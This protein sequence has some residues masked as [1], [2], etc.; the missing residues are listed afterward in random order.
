MTQFM[1]KPSMKNI[2]HS[3]TWTW[4]MRRYMT[5]ACAGLALMVTTGAAQEPM[6]ENYQSV[7]SSVDYYATNFGVF[8]QST[9]SGLPGLTYPRGSSKGY[10][11]GSGLWFGAQKLVGT[12][13]KKLVFVTYNP[14]SAKSWARPGEYLSQQDDAPSLLLRSTD[15]SSFN[16]KYSGAAERPNWP[17][18]LGLGMGATAMRPGIYVPL[19]S[20]RRR[21][22]GFFW[23]AMVEGVAEQF[24]SRF[25]DSSLAL[26]EVVDPAERAG[27]P[28]GLQFQQN[29]FSFEEG[30]YGSVVMI[31]YQIINQSPDTLFHC[32]AGQ[33][34]DPDLGNL[35]NDRLRFHAERPELRSAYVWTDDEGSGHGALAVSIIEA[36]VTDNSGFIDNASRND[37]K[38]MGRAGAFPR[39]NSDASLV[40]FAARYDFMTNG[41]F[42]E[43]E[44]PGDQRALMASTSF[45]MRPGDTAYFTVSYTV[46]DVPP[47]GKPRRGGPRSLVDRNTE[48][49]DSF[50]SLLVDLLDDYY[51]RGV[52]SQV[53]TLGLPEP[54][55]EMSVT[56]MPNPAHDRA[57]ISMTLVEPANASLR[58]TNALG[59]T[60]LVRDLGLRSAG[61]YHEHIDATALPS[62]LYFA[63]VEVGGRTFM[64]RLVL[65]R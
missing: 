23:P 38:T 59:Q 44:G 46:L 30:E 29:I 9:I 31:Q 4:V 54:E 42:A 13:W 2:Q 22:D 65:M 1:R 63:M 7:K 52:F 39:L 15:Y 11:F 28:M 51:E 18:W 35:A 8:G 50:P 27:A 26:Y 53:S 47:A 20:A 58:I 43:D 37:Y 19:N 62:G 16:G 64:T 34:S 14:S 56:A 21:G 55:T 32:V 45:S 49:Q 10:L 25:H 33:F 17:L 24:V 48:Q 60:A 61:T 5:L 6:F 41:M 36:P 12:D 3:I 40:G 57:T